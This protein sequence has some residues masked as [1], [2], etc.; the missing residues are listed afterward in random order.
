MLPPSTA[1]RSWRHIASEPRG[2]GN[3]NAGKT[4]V[5][6]ACAEGLRFT[7]ACLENGAALLIGAGLLEEV[8]LQELVEDISGHLIGAIGIIL[9]V[10][11]LAVFSLQRNVVQF[12]RVPASTNFHATAAQAKEP[13]DD[14]G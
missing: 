6:A 12:R 8:F 14:A 11:R 9:D 2:K 7:L 1:P 3:G 13:V 10:R 5:Q 4:G